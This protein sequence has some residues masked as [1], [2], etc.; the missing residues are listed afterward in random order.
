VGET[1]SNCAADCGCCGAPTADQFS[2]VVPRLLIAP[3]DFAGERWDSDGDISTWFQDYGNFV[4]LAA[5]IA[6]D[7]AYQR[8]TIITAVNLYTQFAQSL[9][10]QFVAPDP[11]V[12]L[13]FLPT[14]GANWELDGTWPDLPPD[15]NLIPGLNVGV[16]VFGP[17]SWVQLRVFDEDL[18]LDDRVG[19]VNIDRSFARAVADCGVVSLVLSP[20]DMDR[21]DT[22]IQAVE[23]EIT[24]LP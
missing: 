20:A 11:L 2:I 9:F 10:S 13:Y 4:E 12:E 6:G 19:E 18:V 14:A 24:S 1:C 5:V 17:D 7:G 23:I 15:T 22:R 3:Y 21:Y 16:F 8:G